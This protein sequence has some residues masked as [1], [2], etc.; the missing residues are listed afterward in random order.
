MKNILTTALLFLA[1][2]G[3]LAAQ[4]VSNIHVQVIGE[5]IHIMYDLSKNA[6]IELYVSFDRG[7]T[8]KGPLQQVTG[9]VGKSIVKGKNKEMTW[10]LVKEVGYIEETAVFK[11]VAIRQVAAQKNKEKIDGEGIMYKPFRVDVGA[12]LSIA[13]KFSFE[14]YFEPKLAVSVVQIRTT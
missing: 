8:W 3:N 4:E 9:E 7:Y 5:K 14:A 10:E 11:I 1:I 2:T 12:G 6:D 13:N